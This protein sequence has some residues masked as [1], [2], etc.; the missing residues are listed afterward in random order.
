MHIAMGVAMAGML[1]ADLNPLRSAV[2]EVVFVVLGV[3]FVW[4]CYTFV[5]QRGVT[6]RDEDHVHHLSH[7]ATHLVMAMAMLYM[8]FAATTPGH[9]STSTAMAMTATGTTTDFVGLP[10]LF[11][12]VLLA[13]GVWEL[14][15]AERFAQNRAT[16]TWRPRCWSGPESR[17]SRLSGPSRRAVRQV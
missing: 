11:L 16:P 13:S 6:G 12:F 5:A 14:D 2:W 3:W 10:L 1:V 4:R 17:L 9:G 15:G 8:Y 7:Y